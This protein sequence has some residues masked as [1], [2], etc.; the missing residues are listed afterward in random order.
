MLPCIIDL[1]ASGFGKGSYPIE[2]GVCLADSS[3]H[4]YL[5]RPENDWL[6]WD[7]EAEKVHGISREIIVEKG[8]PVVEICKRLNQLL[9]NQVVYSDAWGF[10]NTWLWKIYE[11][12]GTYP[13]FKLDTFRKLITEEEIP[14]WN[15]VNQKVIS[16]LGLE[17]HRASSDAMILQET[18]RR[19]KTGN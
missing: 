5:I 3:T 14:R 6:H 17:R 7:K 2:V 8:L 19:I 16:D 10:D 18:F 9:K 12:A 15:D 1:E 11:K 13:N 4:C